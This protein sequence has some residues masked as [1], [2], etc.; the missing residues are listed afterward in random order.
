MPSTQEK[1]RQDTGSITHKALGIYNI[2]LKSYRT[3]FERLWVTLEN[4]R[5]KH[6]AYSN[7]DFKLLWEYV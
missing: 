2:H 4:K 7:I 6:Y 5:V 3:H 1:G